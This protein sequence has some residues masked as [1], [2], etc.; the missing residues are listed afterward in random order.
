M[1]LG[2]TK[3]V[4]QDRLK[5]KKPL[6]LCRLLHA[7]MRFYVRMFPTGTLNTAKPPIFLIN[8]HF[9]QDFRIAFFTKKFPIMFCDADGRCANSLLH[10]TN[11]GP[12]AA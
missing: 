4:P 9:I 2:S 11:S 5:M 6:P 3:K 8:Y 1:L 12:D 7:A 10:P